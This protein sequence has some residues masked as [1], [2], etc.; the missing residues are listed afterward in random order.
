MVVLDSSVTFQVD[1]DGN[2]CTDQIIYIFV[3]P[4]DVTKP[5]DASDPSTIGSLTRSL[6]TWDGSAWNPVTPVAYDVA[7]CVTALTLTYY[8]GSGATTTTP[9]NVRRVGISITGSENIRGYS[10]RTITLSSDVRLR[11]LGQ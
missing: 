10:P 11:N 9:A 5:C 6:Q 8:D 4:T 2:N 7:Q 3:P 1:S